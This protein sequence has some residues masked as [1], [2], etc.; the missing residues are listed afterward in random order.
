MSGLDLPPLKLYK[1]VME[2]DKIPL[3]RHYNREMSWKR[4]NSEA[5]GSGSVLVFYSQDLS[6]TLCIKPADSEERLYTSKQSLISETSCGI[7][8]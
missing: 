4:E 2:K 8:Q 3:I 1:D 6:V 7:M 5:V